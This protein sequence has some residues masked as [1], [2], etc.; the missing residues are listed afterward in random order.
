MTDHGGDPNYGGR[1]TPY[2]AGKATLFEGGTRVPCLMRWPGQIKARSRN[3]SVGSALD[4]FP[5]LA[6][7]AS[8]PA[9][10]GLDGIDITPVLLNG[11]EL[12]DREL[13]W[14]LG[15]HAELDRERWVSIRRGDWKYVQSPTEGEWLFNIAEDP[16][17]KENLRSKQPVRF[18]RLRN[19]ARERSAQY[20]SKD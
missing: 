18:E 11:K 17:E 6:R 5:T 7:L 14:E 3:N 12:G 16:F 20:R 13:F 4:I 9:P 1:N 8:M 15:Q 19:L 10:D 2:R